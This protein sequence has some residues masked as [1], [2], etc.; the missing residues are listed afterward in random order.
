MND[1][2][3]GGD[4]LTVRDLAQI[5]EAVENLSESV[6]SN[7]TS[8]AELLKELKKINEYNALQEKRVEAQQNE[9]NEK[10]R[11]EQEIQERKDKEAE[12]KAQNDAELQAQKEEQQL[13][14]QETYQ[15]ILIDLRT[16]LE[17]SNELQAV[18]TIWFGAILGMLFVK[19][20]W[21]RIIKL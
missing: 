10:A 14:Q 13:N 15:E 9:E 21:D 16:Q 17:L 18:Q 3:T 19:I 20:I 1:E 12:E 5:E 8:D 2:N 6:D 11:V 4:V 7:N